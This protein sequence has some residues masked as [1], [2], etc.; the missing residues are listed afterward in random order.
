MAF[1]LPGI[2]YHT[3][4]A[5]LSKQNKVAKLPTTKNPPLQTKASSR[6]DVKQDH[7]VETLGL[8]FIHWIASQAIKFRHRHTKAQCRERSDFRRI[9][10][11]WG[12][13]S[14]Q[15]AVIT[16]RFYSLIRVKRSSRHAIRCNHQLVTI[17]PT[18][19]LIIQVIVH[20]TSAVTSNPEALHPRSF[21]PTGTRQPS[22]NA[23]ALL[24]FDQYINHASAQNGFPA[25]RKTC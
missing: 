22:K 18:Q 21:Q 6:P 16:P 10:F 23:R 1:V 17:E 20:A 2:Y 3:Q 12:W 5:V 25:F 9:F 15:I 4:R 13:W 14:E 7:T 24:S 11:P 8:A 19:Y